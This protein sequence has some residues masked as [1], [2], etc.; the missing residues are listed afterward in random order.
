MVDANQ[1]L[2]IA[3]AII[4]GK[5]LEQIGVY[6]F[7]E[8]VHA[9]DIGGLSDITKSLHMRVATGETEYG[10]YGFKDLIDRKAA[11]VIQID[12]QRVG[13][14]TEWMR[15]ANMA[16]AWGLKVTPHLFWEISVQLTCAV[17]NAIYI[18]YMD[19]L[20]E[21]FEELPKIKDGF[22]HAWDKPGHGLVFRDDIKK[23]Y[24]VK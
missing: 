2:D 14:I 3:S 20:D 5:E 7:E 8:P 22:V 23:K 9:D 11:D 17:P 12:V 21:F 13:G 16:D 1:G 18:E 10:R 24:I 6:W 15:V 4:L 19:W